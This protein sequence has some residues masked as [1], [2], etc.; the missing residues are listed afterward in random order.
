MVP[1]LWIKAMVPIDRLKMPRV[2]ALL[3][4]IRS[5]GAG[6]DSLDAR[7]VRSTAKSAKK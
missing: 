3:R 5:K 4:F 6:S 7:S 1:D 2:N